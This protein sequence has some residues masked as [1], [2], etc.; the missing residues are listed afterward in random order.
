[1]NDDDR[2]RLTGLLRSLS[3]ADR[4]I[5]RA[6]A[7]VEESAPEVLLTTTEGSA[8]D[9]VWL[10]MSRAGLLSVAEPLEMVKASRVYR[11]EVTAKDAIR[12]L[13]AEVVH[14]DVMVDIVN[15]FRERIPPMVMA[16]IN[17]IEGTPLDLAMIL[18]CVVESTMRT[19]VKPELHDQFLAQ[20]A[21][22]AQSMR[23]PTGA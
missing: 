5:L 21:K 7:S 4:S 22:F 19:W 3:A 6:A 17:R 23:T 1:M 10:A 9:R 18:G 13:L 20:V 16:E 8:N 15:D 11:I 14:G 12:K 2:Y